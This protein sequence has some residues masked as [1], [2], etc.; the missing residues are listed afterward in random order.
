MDAA[1]ELEFSKQGDE[2]GK[3]LWPGSVLIDG[4]AFA[5]S[6]VP[7]TLTLA[8]GG[9]LEA[10][11]REVEGV[12]V[13]ISKTDLATCPATETVLKNQG[14]GKVYLVKETDGHGPGDSSWFLTCAKK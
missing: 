7:T 4:T 13:E 10:G 8:F 5:A 11:V 14:D 1:Q 9:N 2:T 6:I 3:A 12:R